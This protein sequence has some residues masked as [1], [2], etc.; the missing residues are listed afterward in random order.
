MSRGKSSHLMSAKGKL[1]KCLK[2]IV[3]PLDTGDSQ[4]Y[5]SLQLGGDDLVSSLTN[6]EK[7]DIPLDNIARRSKKQHQ[8]QRKPENVYKVRRYCKSCYDK[9]VTK[10][11]REIAREKN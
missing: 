9:N 6:C 4:E 3:S 10:D 5:P 1:S 8:L 2:S 7:E 11:S